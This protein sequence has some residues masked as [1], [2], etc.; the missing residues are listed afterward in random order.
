MAEYV[1]TTVPGKLKALFTKLREVG[2]PQKATSQ[3]LK[4]IGF[5]SSNDASLLGVLK[6]VGL[7]DAS[8]IPTPKWS[9][10]LT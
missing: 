8:G 7:V 10:Y 2:V 4:S 9:S 3:W 6:F 5:M 1:Y